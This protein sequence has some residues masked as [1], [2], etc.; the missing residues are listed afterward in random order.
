M[1]TI[2]AGWFLLQPGMGAG[3]AASRRPNK[4]TIR[5]LNVLAHTAFAVGLFAS[6]WAV[7]GG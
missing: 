7:S 2:G 5:F 1:V 4:W 6:A 3:W